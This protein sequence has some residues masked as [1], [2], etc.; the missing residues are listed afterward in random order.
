MKNTLNTWITISD[1]IKFIPKDFID[2]LYGKL[3]SSNEEGFSV[4]SDSNSETF[5]NKWIRIFKRDKIVWF[6][7]IKVDEIKLW[8]SNWKHKI[9]SVKVNW[10][11]WKAS[12]QT[13]F[14]WFKTNEDGYTKIVTSSLKWTSEVIIS[15]NNDYVEASWGIQMKLVDNF[16]FFTN[17]LWEVNKE[18]FNL[19]N[20]GLNYQY[21]PKNGITEREKFYKV[22]EWWVEK[23]M[24]LWLCTWIT[25][26]KILVSSICNYDWTASI[27]LNLFNKWSII[28]T[29]VFETDWI[30]SGKIN[31][32]WNSYLFVWNQIVGDFWSTKFSF[33]DTVVD[34]NWDI[35]SLGILAFKDDKAKNWIEEMFKDIKIWEKTLFKISKTWEVGIIEWGDWK[36]QWEGYSLW[37]IAKVEITS[38]L[39]TMNKTITYWYWYVYGDKAD[40]KKICLYKVN[41]D[42]FK[43]LTWLEYN[44]RMFWIHTVSNE[45]TFRFNSSL[46][47]DVKS[48]EEWKRFQVTLNLMDPLGADISEV[49]LPMDKDWTRLYNIRWYFDITTWEFI[50][51]DNRIAKPI[52]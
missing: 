43:V 10:I 18:L 28:T 23:E 41:W 19:I 45:D 46:W 49:N 33:T 30:T 34:S 39:Q 29:Q 42:E 27:N 40:T 51:D 47:I 26:N 12:D 24:A 52:V 50:E 25:E 44:W 38:M 5:W 35:L 2:R 36:N 32:N 21:D 15:E 48:K 11:D 3:D 9:Y 1:K 31:I 13:F 37:E 8:N 7:K 14:V 6:S 20:L 22:I 16:K 4:E 17:D